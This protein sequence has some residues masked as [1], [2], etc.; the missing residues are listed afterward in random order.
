MADGQGIENGGNQ[1]TSDWYK[2]ACIAI[3]EDKLQT[4]EWLKSL[5]YS[6]AKQSGDAKYRAFKPILEA[7]ASDEDRLMRLL[8]C[9]LFYKAQVT[10][11]GTPTKCNTK[12]TA[13]KAKSELKKAIAKLKAAKEIIAGMPTGQFVFHDELKLSQENLD[14]RHG[15]TPKTKWDPEWAKREPPKV[16]AE[17]MD[18]LHGHGQWEKQFRFKP[19]PCLQ[20]GRCTHSDKP[21]EKRHCF[22]LDDGRCIEI[23]QRK[24]SVTGQIENIIKMLELQ[25]GV[26]ESELKIKR[27]TGNSHATST[28]PRG[29][30]VVV[31][32]DTTSVMDGTIF[33]LY[34]ILFRIIHGIECDI[35]THIE[36]TYF[37]AKQIH[38]ERTGKTWKALDKAKWG[39]SV[40]ADFR[41]RLES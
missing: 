9:R 2:E 18:N 19:P 7:I 1:D 6:T 15:K 28:L 12:M 38:M 36:L 16:F 40:R 31:Y 37:L 27:K 13:G 3:E 17:H 33:R 35:D 20:D 39:E 23:P 41:K 34:N 22:L 14:R 4:V 10:K 30:D 25:V 5:D 29:G 11:K 8:N 24:Y 21:L 26:E 32:K